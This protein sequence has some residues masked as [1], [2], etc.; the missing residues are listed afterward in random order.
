MSFACSEVTFK[1]IMLSTTFT[2]PRLNTSTAA[3]V[4]TAALDLQSCLNSDTAVQTEVTPA[5]IKYVETGK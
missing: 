4:T 5:Q 2:V 1:T 3:V